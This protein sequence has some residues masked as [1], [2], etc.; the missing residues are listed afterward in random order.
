LQA[1]FNQAAIELRSCEG[2]YMV[3]VGSRRTRV[4][5]IEIAYSPDGQRIAA[6][7]LLTP[8]G[9]LL[10]ADAIE[11]IRPTA[12]A[13][14]GQLESSAYAP[15]EI[16]VYDERDGDYVMITMVNEFSPWIH[17]LTNGGNSVGGSVSLPVDLAAGVVLAIRKLCGG[18][19][20]IGVVE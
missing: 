12:G 19:R 15:R 16:E 5:Y 2:D 10:V 18:Q 1:S 11:K 20:A 17:L 14:G 8:E 9:S 13:A 3:V 7:L 6:Q 4:D